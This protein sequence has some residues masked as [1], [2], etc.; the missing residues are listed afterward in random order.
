KPVDS[1]PATAIRTAGPPSGAPK[2][3]RPVGPGAQ[4]YTAKPASEPAARG[5]AVSRS[6]VEPGSSHEGSTK[7]SGAPVTPPSG[8]ERSAQH[9]TPAGSRITPAQ[10]YSSAESGSGRDEQL[11][12]AIEKVK[13]VLEARNKIML[14]IALE[15]AEHA[16]IEGDY[17]I[18]ASLRPTI[19]T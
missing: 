17:L 3:S 4:S 5:G 10:E 9:S 13:K 8:G 14:S 16:S 2:V 18:R 11:S 7:S 15:R 12:T 6:C 19:T 1:R